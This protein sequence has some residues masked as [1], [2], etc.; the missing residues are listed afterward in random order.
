M[1]LALKVLLTS[2][3]SCPITHLADDHHAYHQCGPASHPSSCLCAIKQ[4]RRA[5]A[6]TRRRLMLDLLHQHIHFPDRRGILQPRTRVVLKALHTTPTSCAMGNAITSK[7]LKNWLQTSS[8]KEEH[9]GLFG[10]RNRAGAQPLL[11]T[12]P[13]CPGVSRC[14]TSSQPSTSRSSGSADG[15]AGIHEPRSHTEGLA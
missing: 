8:Y 9:E 13:L 14:F 7:G 6:A 2:V 15:S 11:Q 12:I 5:V 3:A 4:G 1:P 10:T